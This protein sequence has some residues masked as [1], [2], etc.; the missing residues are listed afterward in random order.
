[1]LLHCSSQADSLGDIVEGLEVVE[2]WDAVVG[3]CVVSDEV[4]RVV[5]VVFEDWVDE[6]V[7]IC[8]VLVLVEGSEEVDVVLDEVCRVVVE[9]WVET[10]VTPCE[11]LEASVDVIGNGS[12]LLYLWIGITITPPKI[13]TPIEPIYKIFKIMNKSP[14]IQ[15]MNPHK[16]DQNNQEKNLKS[17]HCCSFVSRSKV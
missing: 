10:W 16:G 12:S 6:L 11:V 4:C 3:L 8:E 13:I 5:G 17:Q 9:G 14:L 15:S 2:D 1:M 7:D